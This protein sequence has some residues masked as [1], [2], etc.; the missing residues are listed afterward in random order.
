MRDDAKLWSDVD[1]Y[2]AELF[3]APD[4]ALTAALQASAAAGLPDISVAPNQ[5]KLLNLLVHMCKARRIL[6]IGTLGGYSTIWMAR[7][8][9]MDGKL[10]TLELDATH[11]AIAHS[12]FSRAGLAG[13]IELRHGAAL[14]SLEQLLHSGTDPFDLVFID[15]DKANIPGYFE[16]ALKLTRL[17]S[18]IIVD[19]VVRKGAVIDA[20][21][22]DASV[23]GV[24]RFNEMVAREP[25][26]SATALQ[27]VG[28]KGYDGLAIMLVV[29]PFQSS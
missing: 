20:N 13:V 17:G 14:H 12:N 27:T 3:V 21:S 19:N 15:A 16:Y 11:A 7:A 18:V 8:L 6:E 1:R 26:V 22:D 23:Q 9:P 25:R 29:N 24:R 28:V 5:G 2:F 4:E 10:I